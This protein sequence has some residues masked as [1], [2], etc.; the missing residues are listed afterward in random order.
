MMRCD[1]MRESATKAVGVFHWGFGVQS[2]RYTQVL[3]VHCLY[4]VR[5]TPYSVLKTTLRASHVGNQS[6]VMLDARSLAA[7]E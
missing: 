7:N 3:R 2:T 1:V 4:S 5:S 6:V